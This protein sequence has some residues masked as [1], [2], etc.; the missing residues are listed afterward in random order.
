MLAKGLIAM[1]GSVAFLLKLLMSGTLLTA[2]AW[3]QTESGWRIDTIAGTGKPGFGGDGGRSVE[4]QLD[5]PVGV[6]VDHAGNVYISE[7]YS[8]R[9]RRVDAARTIDTIAGTGEPSYGGD[10]GPAVRARFSFPSGVAVDHAGNLSTSP[11]PAT[12]AFAEWTLPEPSPPLRGPESRSGVGKVRR[13]RCRWNV[14]E[15]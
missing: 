1:K 7:H 2:T 6:A 4:A 3:P 5:F 13:S 9:I 12:T 11:I 14:L 8:Q 10:G 15:A